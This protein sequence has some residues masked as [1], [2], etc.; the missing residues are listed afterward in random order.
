MMLLSIA[1]ILKE[2]KL[3]I[4]EKTGLIISTTKGNIDVLSPKSEF[5]KEPKRAYLSELGRQIQ[6]FF[7]FKEEAIVVSNACVSGVLAI[8]IAKHFIQADHYNDVIM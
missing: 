2:S 6:D 3:K 7:N 4:T 5:Y 8:S 1:H